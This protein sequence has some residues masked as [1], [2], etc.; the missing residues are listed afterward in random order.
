MN[1][2]DNRSPY[3]LDLDK[4]LIVDDL[5]LNRRLMTM[6]FHNTEFSII[7]AEGGEEALTKAQVELPFLIIT[8]VQM[9][10]MDGT[11]SA[12]PSKRHLRQ[13]TLPSF[14]SQ[15]ITEHR[16]SPRG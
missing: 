7:E 9:P 4:I 10:I 16:I 1:N 13:P 5:P 2:P 8:D 3:D 11:D 12:K 14:T 6:M 15:R